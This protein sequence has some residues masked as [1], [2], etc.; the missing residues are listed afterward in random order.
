MKTRVDIMKVAALLC[1]VALARDDER[2]FLK[3]VADFE[4]RYEASEFAKRF[5]I[6]KQNLDRIE[7]HNA[8]GASWT[9]GVNQFADM[10]PSEFKEKVVGNNDF[11]KTE[12][13]SS[14]RP[15]VANFT[16]PLRE[17]DRTLMDVTSGGLNWKGACGP[18]KD[19]GGC[20]GCWAFAAT[21]VIECRYYAY[22]RDEAK[23]DVSEQE[24]IDCSMDYDTHGCNYG[25]VWG[26]YQY[27]EDHGG[28]CAADQYPY[29]ARQGRSCKA[30]SCSNTRQG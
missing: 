4:K 25:Q 10:T 8:S 19:Q 17:P 14:F 27:S 3:F 21:G 30:T 23:I 5:Q 26:A 20:G 22:H 9:M 7:K 18:V 29:K 28:L 15:A 13:G 16:K 24:L 6:F 12:L 11:T 2:Q 1:G